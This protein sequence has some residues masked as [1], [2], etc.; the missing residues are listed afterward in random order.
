MN[1]AAPASLRIV[2]GAPDDTELAV[3]VAVLAAVA[4][5]DR[6]GPAAEPESASW[7]RHEGAFRPVQTWQARPGPVR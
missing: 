6:V 1:A 4:R 5:R 2:R 3:I 7:C